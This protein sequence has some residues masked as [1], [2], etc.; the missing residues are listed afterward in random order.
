MRPAPCLL[1]GVSW[2]FAVLIPA[3]LMVATFGLERLE[4][5]LEDHDD[6]QDP[7]ADLMVP[8]AVAPAPVASPLAHDADSVQLSA[9]TGGLAVFN[10]EPGLPTRLCRH[11]LGNPQFRPTRHA[12]PV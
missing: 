10:D 9:A 6:D 7:L 12:N 11:D 5:A 2:L 8:I 1:T 3:L 4:A